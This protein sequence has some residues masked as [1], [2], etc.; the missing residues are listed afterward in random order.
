MVRVGF[1]DSFTYNGHTARNNEELVL[2]LRTELVSAGFSIATPPE[3][4]EILLS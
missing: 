3:A 2:A 4:K 1:E